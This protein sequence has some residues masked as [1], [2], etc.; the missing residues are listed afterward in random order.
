M[1]KL[2]I[3][4]LFPFT[5][6]GQIKGKALHLEGEWRYKEG[7]GKEVWYKQGDY[8]KGEGFRITKFG[9]TVKVEDLALTRVNGVML[10]TY[11]RIEHGKKI[12]TMTLVSKNRKLEFVSADPENPI[13]LTYKL[14]ASKNKL[15]IYVQFNEGVKP[16][17]LTLIRIPKPLGK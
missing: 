13:K 7:S 14:S 15:R 1:R 4:A 12:E 16:N 17:R 3:F 9:D 11:N 6:M 5:L 2:L 10:Y 8:L